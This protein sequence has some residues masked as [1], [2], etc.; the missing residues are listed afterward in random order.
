MRFGQV[1]AI[2]AFAFVQIRHGIGPETINPHFTPDINDVE[3]FLLHLWVVV[4]EIGLVVKKAMPVILLR[5]WVP[6][7][8]SGF[9]VLKYDAYVFILSRVVGPY[10]EISFG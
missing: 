5:N 9:K 4:I 3:Y 8:V 6:G 10:I 2:G 7:P 1:L